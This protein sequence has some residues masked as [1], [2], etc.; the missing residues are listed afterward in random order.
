MLERNEMS[1]HAQ[2]KWNVYTYLYMLKRNEMSIHIYTCS[3]EMKCLYMLKRI[4]ISIHVYTCS[5]ETKCLYMLKRKKWLYVLKRKKCLYLLKRNAMSIHVYTCSKETK[6]LYML[7]RK[8]WLYVLKRNKM[9]VH[10]Q[11]KQNAYKEQNHSAMS[12]HYAERL[13]QPCGFSVEIKGWFGHQFPPPFVNWLQKQLLA[14]HVN[15]TAIINDETQCLL[16][17]IKGGNHAGC[18]K[19]LVRHPNPL[20][21][22]LQQ[23]KLVVDAMAKMLFALLKLYTFSFPVCSI[24]SR[25]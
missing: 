3:K 1:I 14:W 17:E 6:C 9:P 15:E 24:R 13:F 7:K 22:C 4:E 21:P 8:N 10:A 5:K 2:K 11:K 23:K 12:W 25:W 20:L 16:N 18:E 19:P